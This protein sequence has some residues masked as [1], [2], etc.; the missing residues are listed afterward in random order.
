MG[1]FPKKNT[2]FMHGGSHYGR[3]AFWQPLMG[4]SGKRR[5]A[6][7]R[8]VI[9]KHLRAYFSEPNLSDYAGGAEL[10]RD[11]DKKWFDLILLDM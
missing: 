3:G 7:E 9:A 4:N 8:A 2:G 11:H 1:N 6:E 10:V 5:E